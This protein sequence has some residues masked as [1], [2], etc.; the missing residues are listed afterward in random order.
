MIKIVQASIIILCLSGS[1]LTLFLIHYI[2][3]E[4]KKLNELTSTTNDMAIARRDYSNFQIEQLQS[5]QSQKAIE[6]SLHIGEAGL[7][8]IQKINRTTIPQLNAMLLEGTS[9]LAT[10]KEPS[11]RLSNLI[12][13]LDNEVNSKLIP[14]VTERVKDL[15]ATNDEVIKAIKS[16]NLTVEDLRKIANNENIPAIMEN[17]KKK[18]EKKKE[19]KKKIKKKNIKKTE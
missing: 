18:K 9:T 13:N 5:N 19:E 14:E 1:L 7:L 4:S 2:G 8:T 10:L 16:A 6:H 15:G 17:L 3:L 11:K 12:S